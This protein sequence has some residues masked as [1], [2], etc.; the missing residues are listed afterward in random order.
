MYWSIRLKVM[1]RSFITEHKFRLCSFWSSF[2]HES[3][4]NRFTTK[5]RSVP[6][7]IR[8]LVVYSSFAAIPIDGYMKYA[9]SSHV[10]MTVFAFSLLSSFVFNSCF[11]V[12]EFYICMSVF[13][14][15]FLWYIRGQS[16]FVVLCSSPTFS[17][18]DFVA[19]S[20]S[21]KWVLLHCFCHRRHVGH[22]FGASGSG[23]S[24]FVYSTDAISFC[25]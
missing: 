21:L 19:L 3:R 5:F 9:A 10:E 23:M 16:S 24:V 14:R 15:V 12:F 7:F 4:R 22:D 8:Q 11:L 6:L 13:A 25:R 1:I 2:I 18:T 20:D 17:S